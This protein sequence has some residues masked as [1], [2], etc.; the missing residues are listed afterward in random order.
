MTKDK[1][2]FKIKHDSRKIVNSIWTMDTQ[3]SKT[4]VI[5]NNPP[6]F[7]KCNIVIHPVLNIYL[8]IV[9]YLYILL[10]TQP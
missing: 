2:I 8:F 1:K 5:L 3:T 9:F 7:N 10:N 4:K 6:K